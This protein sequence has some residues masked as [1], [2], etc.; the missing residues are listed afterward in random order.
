MSSG[1]A[2][3]ALAAFGL[4]ELATSEPQ[5]RDYVAG[6]PSVPVFG[7][8]SC[9]QESIQSLTV[10]AVRGNRRDLI[11]SIRAKTPEGPRVLQVRL[12]DVPVG[13]E[14]THALPTTSD[15]NRLSFNI[16]TTAGGHAGQAF[17]LSEIRD[18]S[19]LWSAGYAAGT[20]LDAIASS[21]F[22]C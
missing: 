6:S 22:G 8:R 7:Y 11:W 9:G 13:F 21:R 5:G 16:V 2:V 1:L 10:R 19:V 18:G 12:G 3:L 17:D 4:T 14:V 20:N 15:W